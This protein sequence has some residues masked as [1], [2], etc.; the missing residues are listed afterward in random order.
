MRNRIQL[1]SVLLALVLGLFGC[2]ST[3]SDPTDSLP[4][5]TLSP[6]TAKNWYTDAAEQLQK[7][8]KLT[9]TYTYSQDRTV[10]ADT[11]TTSLT[12]TTTYTGQSSDKATAVVQQS[13]TYGTYG[14]QY[15]ELY[16]D[17][18]AYIIANDCAFAGECDWATFTARQFPAV[19]LDATLYGSIQ[20]EE[21]E[22]GVKVTFSGATA[23]EAWE[24]A[25]A[26]AVLISAEGSATLD[27]SHA[28]TGF[29]Y[30]VSYTLGST[31]YKTSLS[32]SVSPTAAL[33]L[34]ENFDA[35][36]QNYT[37]LECLDAPKLLLRAVGD[38]FTVGSFTSEVNQQVSSAALDLIRIDQNSFSLSGSGKEMVASADY[39]VT[40]SDY[41]GATTTTSQSDRFANGLLT[42]ISNGSAPVEATE[43]PENIRIRWENNLLN[44]LFA[45]TYLDGAT[46]TETEDF[47]ILNFTGNDAY[48]SAISSSLNTIFSSDLDSLATSYTDTLATGYLTVN[49]QTGLPTA[50]GMAFSR[51]HVLYDVAYPLSYQL[52]QKL[53]LSNVEDD[54]TAA[55]IPEETQPTP[56]FYQVTGADGQQLWLLGTIHVGDARTDDLPQQIYDALRSADSLAVEY[57]INAFLEQVTNDPATQSA[58]AEIYYYQDGTGAVDHLTPES[59]EQALIQ[60]T[61]SGSYTSSIPYMRPVFLASLLEEF[62]LEQGYHL[63]TDNG[64]DA[65][66][67]TL[68]S[69]MDKNVIS[70]ESGLTQLQL[71]ASLSD[72]AQQL[73]LDSTLENGLVGYNSEINTLYELWCKGDAEALLPL[74]FADDESATE[75]VRSYWQE[76]DQALITGRNATMLKVAIEC[77]ESKETVFYAVGIAH[78][79]GEN[80]LV[81]QLE[82]AGYT[83]QQVS[84]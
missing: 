30:T 72:E 23:L 52:D 74:L 9:M 13:I 59:Y 8:D 65:R 63:S 7:A 17:G 82:D 55:D 66:L 80:G 75:E 51:T 5:A 40:L 34:P 71:L 29:T 57:D 46:M 47:Y 20:P 77:L 21:T 69:I 19:V 50:L 14:V 79:L 12:G 83:V 41:R 58:L 31:V 53:Y 39:Q 4:P 3:Q 70:I 76:Y 10:G 49:K 64:V 18:N 73:L 44:G 33:D 2:T 36:V 81:A 16:Q 25:S 1:L 26:E 15:Q 67:L 43:T 35:D 48:R 28:L 32:L 6:D 42:R 84:Y 56:L 78:L 24:C 11:F 60:L 61:A 54:D 38:I 45:L 22:D 27:G 62:Y 68:A 37:K